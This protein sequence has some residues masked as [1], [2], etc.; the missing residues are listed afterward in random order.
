MPK[1]EM[2]RTYLG[3]D[4]DM[5][6]TAKIIFGSF[7]EDKD[8]FRTFDSDYGDA[9]IT[10][11]KIDLQEAEDIAKIGAVTGELIG[12]SADVESALEKSKNYFL[13]TK[14]FVEKAFT[15]NR[16][17]WKEF[18]YDSYEISRRY[19]SEMIQFMNQFYNAAMKYKNELTAVNYS[20]QM[21]DEIASLKR[22]LDEANQRQENFK[23]SR[24]TMTQD[25][26]TKLN[27]CW[28]EIS[29]I[30]RLGKLIFA[31]DFGRYQKYVINP[32]GQPGVPAPPEPP[33]APQS[34]Q[35]QA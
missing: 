32:S 35:G 24:T 19:Q 18:G 30:A 10:R 22:E 3:S 9:F 15:D 13:L 6:Q 17:V 29:E 14:H 12:L 7:L 34:T 26:L 8:A 21:I 2:R 4:A 11:F 16:G 20:Q 27:S 33:Q 25:R 1:T 23:K 5:I 31:N 28:K